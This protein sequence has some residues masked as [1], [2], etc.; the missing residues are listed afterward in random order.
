MFFKLEGQEPK[1][2][3]ADEFEQQR[4]DNV[5]IVKVDTNAD[6]SVQ[7]STIFV[8][9]DTVG[10]EPP[11]LFETMLFVGNTDSKVWRYASWNEA[12]EGHQAAVDKYL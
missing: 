10:T 3:S 2:C 12:I 8:G 7:V 9:V 5:H 1:P 4:K 11:M 6:R